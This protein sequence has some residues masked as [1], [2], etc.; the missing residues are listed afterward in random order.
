MHPQNER[1]FVLESIL[2][3]GGFGT[4]YLA[5][6]EDG[7]GFT[8]QVALKLLQDPHPHPEVLQ[9]FR[10]EARLL[11]LLRDRAIVGVEPPVQLD[12]QW[13]VVMEYVDGLSCS[14][15][16]AREGSLPTG[17]ALEIITEIARALGKAW[18]TPGPDGN[19]LHLIHRDLK[20]SNVQITRTG[21]VKIL[22]FGLAKAAFDAR[23]ARTEN[24]IAGTLGYIA[25]E[26]FEGQ[27]G[28]TTDVYSLGVML[29]QLMLGVRHSSTSQRPDL[30]PGSPKQLAIALALRM[31]SHQPSERPDA[32][33]VERECADLLRG[34]PS[35]ETLRDWAE[36]VIPVRPAGEAA[37]GELVDRAPVSREVPS[38]LTSTAVVAGGTT[39]MLFFVGFVALC[40]IGGLVASQVV[41]RGPPVAVPSSVEPVEPVVVAVP[42]PV[43]PPAPVPPPTEEPVPQP[44]EPVP[45]PEPPPPRPD[46]APRPAP[47]REPV[48][49]DPEP[50][51]VYGV[52]LVSVP[53]DAEVYIDG[54]RRG[55]TP[56]EVRLES[57]SHTVTMALGPQRTQQ[58]I[59]VGRRAPV[60][61]V[62][63]VDHEE[64]KGVYR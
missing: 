24:S 60:R 5:R 63:R 4:V 14:E 61:Y 36:R 16:L 29:E 32:R 58:V 48:A 55:V 7:Q 43:T 41:D 25:P 53:P 28:P 27:E 59:R 3:Q 10:D 11:G 64:W 31:R 23:E 46:P 6:L 30:V 35:R 40:G 37:H 12:G 13:A 22:D 33:D 62:W 2:G 44:V 52:T 18:T 45:H 38:S 19:P 49:E 15:L 26:R 9:R 54:T 1:R 8:K 34:F 47:V 21:E 20:P 50:V 57:G 39:V 17:V 56:I 42:E 51:V